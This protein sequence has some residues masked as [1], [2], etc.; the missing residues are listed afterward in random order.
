MPALDGQVLGKVYKLSILMA[1]VGILESAMTLSLID[2]RTKTKGS[3]MRE[4]VGQGV[5]NVVCGLCGGMGGCAMLGQSMINVSA[6]ARGRLSTLSCSVFLLFILLVG[7]PAINMLPVAAL[8]GVMFNVVY[9]TFEWGSLRLLMVAALPKTLRNLF[10]AEEQGRQKKIRRVDALV[11]V[12]VTVVTLLADLCVAVGCGVALACFMHVYDAASMIRATSH[13]QRDAE[14]T[15]QVKT[16]EVHGVL[17]F[18]SATAFLELFDVEGDPQ[19]VR[20]VFESSYIADFSALEALNKLGERYGELGKRVKLQLLHP[21]SS[22]I[23]DKAS[24]LLVKE[25]TLSREDD[26]VLD[27]PRFRHHIESYSQSF[28]TQA[29]E[30]VM[31]QGEVEQQQVRQ[32]PVLPI[33][34]EL[35]SS[36]A[37]Q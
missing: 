32:R 26:R 21:G 28:M 37:S 4:C 24:N 25:L 36:Q 14:G 8:A 19:E 13:V 16:Y 9:Q 12:L 18:G 1:V 22:R 34:S 10:L 27:S 23:V 20:V 5:A 35:A 17:F 33:V 7:Y 3:V 30:T 31:G 2:E 11:I 6:G 29:A 15:E